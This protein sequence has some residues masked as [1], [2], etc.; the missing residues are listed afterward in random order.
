[1][2]QA[3]AF[4]VFS[5]LHNCFC[6]AVIICMNPRYSQTFVKKLEGG[7]RSARGQRNSFQHGRCCSLHKVDSQGPLSVRGQ[8]FLVRSAAAVLFTLHAT[9]AAKSLYLFNLTVD[10][11][12]LLFVML[13]LRPWAAFSDVNKNNVNESN[14]S[15]PP[16]PWP[17]LTSPWR[18]VVLA[19]HMTDEPRP[20]R[21][22]SV[23]EPV[24]D[25]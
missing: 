15:C 16:R 20:R 10:A 5:F 18:C 1:M 11:C 19:C 3:F 6:K 13:V 21:R 2:V 24:F 17:C 12:T 23:S 9:K 8:L 25:E 22:H 14:T 7:E 4:T